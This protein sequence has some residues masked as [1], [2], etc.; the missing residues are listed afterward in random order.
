MAGG[1]GGG[2]V[3]AGNTEVDMIVKGGAG[4]RGLAL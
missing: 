1:G 2:E 4:A 3:A